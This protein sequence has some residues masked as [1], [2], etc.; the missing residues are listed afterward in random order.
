[1]P[2]ARPFRSLN[3]TR[4]QA[5]H[6]SGSFRPIAMKVGSES[7]AI[8]TFMVLLN[9]NLHVVHWPPSMQS[10]T[11]KNLADHSI[12]QT[13]RACCIARGR[14]DTLSAA[15]GVCVSF[16][17]FKDVTLVVSR[18]EPRIVGFWRSGR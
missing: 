2:F 3:T 7:H 12:S 1:M 6:G 15:L 5:F 9:R 10:L 8:T 4:S 13:S 16:P 14:Y 17:R 11:D 18:L